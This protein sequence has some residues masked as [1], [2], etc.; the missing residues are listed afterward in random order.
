M[1]VYASANL[2]NLDRNLTRPRYDCTCSPELNTTR[3]HRCRIKLF[4]MPEMRLQRRGHL[5][6]LF[7][8]RF[9]IT[10]IGSTRRPCP[11]PRIQTRRRPLLRLRH[12]LYLQS[13]ESRVAQFLLPRDDI[14]I[15]FKFMNAVG[16]RLPDFAGSNVFTL[17]PI[18]LPIIALNLLLP[19]TRRPAFFL[20]P[21]QF[22]RHQ[23]V[24]I[25]LYR[26][27]IYSLRSQFRIT[28]KSLGS[29]WLATVVQQSLMLLDIHFQIGDWISVRQF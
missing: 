26:G 24:I 13:G 17:T 6:N 1:V 12:H 20:I 10:A 28:L 5:K 11:I 27:P 3:P 19:C 7:L 21:Y 18:P 15:Y 14:I 16:V 25:L 2:L 8:S 9:V 29:E 4:Q 22:R 23:M